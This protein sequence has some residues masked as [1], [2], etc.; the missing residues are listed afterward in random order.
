MLLA[1]LAGV[2]LTLQIGI[3]VHLRQGVGH[4]AIAAFISFLVGALVLLAYALATRLS[5]PSWSTVLQIP[6]WAWVGGV[7]GA[8]YVGSTIALSPRLGAA[9][10]VVLVVAGQLLAALVMDH[11]GWLGATA[12]PI[13]AWRAAG[14]ALV[15]AGVFLIQRH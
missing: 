13:N 10:F 11:M 15:V 8:F 1:L 5:W 9:L 3:N 7:L 6:P 12:Q 2:A 14:A 4:A